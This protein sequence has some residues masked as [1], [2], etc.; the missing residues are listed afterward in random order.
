MADPVYSGH[1]VEKTVY[2]KLM[3]WRLFK[4]DS[5]LGSTLKLRPLQCGFVRQQI[6]E[7]GFEVLINPSQG[8]LW[9]AY[10]LL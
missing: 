10:G 2:L 3:S 8:L 7:V 1:V 5:V 6:A 9:V 4:F